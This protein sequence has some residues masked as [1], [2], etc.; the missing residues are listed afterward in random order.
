MPLVP[1]N[2][3]LARTIRR[4]LELSA[5]QTTDLSRRQERREGLIEAIELLSEG[6]AE[7]EQGVPGVPG[8]QKCDDPGG[9]AVVRVRM[10]RC[11]EASRTDPVGESTE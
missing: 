2:R 10:L 11:L 5:N 4:Y 1:E 8:S 6:G 9:A 7:G 3:V